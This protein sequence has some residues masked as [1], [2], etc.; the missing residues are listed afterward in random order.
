MDNNLL[1]AIY[2]TKRQQLI[3]GFNTPVVRDSLNEAYVYAYYQRM[4]PYFH[5]EFDDDI[6]PFADVYNITPSLVREVIEYADNVWMDKT[7]PN[8]SFYDYESHFGGHH[9]QRHELIAIFRY[10]SLSGRFDKVFF[11]DL[12]KNGDAPCEANGLNE[13]LESSEIGL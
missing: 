2:E 7:T 13:P 9:T 10:A 11:N 4:F 3:L 12:L 8:L 1:K 5:N 6:D